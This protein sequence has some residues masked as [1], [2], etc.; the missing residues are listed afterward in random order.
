MENCDNFAT[1][2]SSW[3]SG[4]K[5]KLHVSSWYMQKIIIILHM[6]NYG[7]TQALKSL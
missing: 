3:Q 2:A 7:L 5:D 1:D 4:T 6:G